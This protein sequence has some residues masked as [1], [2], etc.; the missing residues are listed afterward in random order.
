MIIMKT[1]DFKEFLKGKVV[2]DG[3]VNTQ[4]AIRAADLS[5]N[6]GLTAAIELAR[7]EVADVTTK[8]KSFP[9]GAPLEKGFVLPLQSS[10]V[11]KK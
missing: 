10:F 8:T 6:N 1:V 11:L 4:R 2:A 5:L 3:M 9:L 7:T